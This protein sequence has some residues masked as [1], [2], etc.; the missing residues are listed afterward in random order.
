M[1]KSIVIRPVSQKA[2]DRFVER[3]SLV[4]TDLHKRDAMFAALDKYLEG[5]RDTYDCG[6]TP[7]CMLAFGMLRFEIDQAMTRSAKARMRA[8]K[9]RKAVSEDVNPSRKTDEPVV[10]EAKPVGAEAGRCSMAD[11]LNMWREVTENYSAKAGRSSDGK[12]CDEACD[13]DGSDDMDYDENEVF[14]APKTRRQRRAEQRCARPKAR[15]SK[16]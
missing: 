12:A 13:N 8:R 6:L 5:D 15:W 7:D 11:L 9:R 16:L 1:K 3:I 14:V 10:D 2:Y 4:I